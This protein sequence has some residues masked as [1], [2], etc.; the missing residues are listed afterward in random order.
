MDFLGRVYDWFT[1]GDHWSGQSGIPNR[2]IEHL[3]LSIVAMLIAMLIALPV[4]LV[5]GHTRKGGAVAVNVSNIGRAIPSFALLVL[6]AQLWGIGEIAGMSKAALLAL[7][8]LAIPPIVTN[9]YVGMSGV[10]E[11]I[12]DSAVGV[13]M[14]SWQ[15]L[16]RVE[17]PIALPLVMAG[18][19]ISALQVIA[20]ATLAAVVASGG[21]GRFIV[22]GIAVRD[23]PKV[24]AGALLV[25]ALA[26]TIEGV[27]A[28]GQRAL[29]S[30]GLRAE[31]PRRGRQ[32]GL[33][34][35]ANLLL[36]EAGSIPNREESL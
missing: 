34:A 5:L 3:Q 2:M 1:D 24:F 9:T 30:D 28:L 32:P 19:R 35:Q 33:D 36:V 13:G 26:L 29:V 22:D 12:R 18:I 4:G 15:R 10:D 11:G 25:A 17:L 8:A 31:G 6:G 23:F 21:L 20:T 14:R 7:V 16:F 27:L